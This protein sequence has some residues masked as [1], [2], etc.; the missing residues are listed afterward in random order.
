MPVQPKIISFGFPSRPGSRGFS[1]S[2]RHDAKQRIRRL[3]PHQFPV[4]RK[5]ICGELLPSASFVKEA[6]LELRHVLF[7]IHHPVFA[8]VK[9]AFPAPTFPAVNCPD[10]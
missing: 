1:F 8:A 7:F 5:T 10:L 9:T 3:R 4:M 2:F 6:V